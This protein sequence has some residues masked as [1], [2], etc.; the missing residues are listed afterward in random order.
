M[1]RNGNVHCGEDY[2]EGLAV[3]KTFL[4]FIYDTSGVVV[5]IRAESIDELYRRGLIKTGRIYYYISVIF[6]SLT[7][8][9]IFFGLLLIVF[10]IPIL[11]YVALYMGGEF[12]WLSLF[13]LFDTLKKRKITK[14]ETLNVKDGKLITKKINFYGNRVKITGRVVSDDFDFSYI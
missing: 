4:Y 14:S 5:E 6:A 9:W 1:D 3:M 8:T 7:I 13:M 12:L 10:N 2:S 11:L